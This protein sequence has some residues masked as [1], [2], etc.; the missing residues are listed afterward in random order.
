MTGK[1]SSVSKTLF[2]GFGLILDLI[3]IVA[4]IFKECFRSKK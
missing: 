1:N 3:I 4:S 2:F